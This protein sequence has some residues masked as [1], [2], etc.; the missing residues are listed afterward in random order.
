MSKTS[1][2]LNEVLTS[3][4]A[5]Y[6]KT[7]NYHWNVEGPQFPAL[8]GL[9]ESQY[10]E[11]R[12]LIDEV[13]ERI[14]A[15]GGVPATKV[16][17]SIEGLTPTL[18]MLK[19]LASGHLGLSARMSREYIPALGDEDPGSVDLLTRAHQTHDKFAWMLNATAR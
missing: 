13:A 19:N 6:L 9:F 15:L 17:L 10:V 4:L 3:E 18:E 7:W 16:S 5:L 2:I 14:R 11:L 1:Q 12:N 8:H